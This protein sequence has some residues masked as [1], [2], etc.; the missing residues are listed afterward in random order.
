M[1]NQITKKRT[2]QIVIQ[3]LFVIVSLTLLITLK[4]KTTISTIINEIEHEYGLY[5]IDFIRMG[6]GI[7]I[8][9]GA[10]GFFITTSP[11]RA[12]WPAHYRRIFFSIFIFCNI[13]SQ[14]FFNVFSVPTNK[15]LVCILGKC[16]KKLSRDQR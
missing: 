15:K 10:F 11:H 12:H 6:L 2:Q 16:V 14:A 5:A 3:L 1:K 9:I 13:I 4:A 8:I 7:L